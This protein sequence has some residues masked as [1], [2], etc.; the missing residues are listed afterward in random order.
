MKYQVIVSNIGQV[1]DGDDEAEARRLYT[2]Y[3]EK[4]KGNEGRAA[5]EN[6]TVMKD[7]EPLFDFSGAL[8]DLEAHED[9]E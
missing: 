4:S 1:Y 7:G 9:G 3:V 5:G 2:L 8:G 6:V